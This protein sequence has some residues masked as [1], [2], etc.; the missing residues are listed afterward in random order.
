MFKRKIYDQLLSWK[1]TKKQECLLIN[2]ARQVGKTFIVNEFGKNEYD[3]YIYINFFTNPEYMEIFAGALDAQS[4]YKNISVYLKTPK[5]QEHNTL[6]FLDEIQHCPN[7]RTA[8]KFL[9]L[10]D[11]YDVVASGSLLGLNYKKVDSIPV[12]YEKQIDMFPLD[13]EEFLWA[14]GYSEDGISVLKEFFDKTQAVPPQLNEIYLR[15]VREYM[16]VGGMPEVVKRYCATSN[17]YEVYLAQK[18]ILRDYAQDIRKYAGA[19]ERQKIKDCYDSLPEQL[20]KENKKFQYTMV[21]QQG[22][23]RKYSNSL[24]WLEDAGLIRRCYNVTVPELPLRAYRIANQFKVYVTDIGLLTAMYGRATQAALF[25]GT[26]KGPAKGGIFENLVFDIFL[27]NDVD[28]FYYKNAQSTQEIEFIFERES[29]EIVP[30]EVKAGNGATISL[31]NFIKKYNPS[32]AYKVIDGNIGERGAKI[33]IP[34]YMA[35]WAG[36]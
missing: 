6:I 16:V 31:N 1:Q 27:S 10:D 15:L 32:V 3:N 19:T 21:G 25:K 33:T 12:G 28:V 13:L 11:R 23:A 26:L 14:M 7:A 2:G 30:V 18:K 5:M 24:D 20:A 8:L 17:L 34:F 4:I 35:I 36:K 22:N 9:A 29:G